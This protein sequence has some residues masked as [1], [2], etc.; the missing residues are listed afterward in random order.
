MI[1]IDKL[2]KCLT[3]DI[4]NYKEVA[5]KIGGLTDLMDADLSAILPEPTG[6]VFKE[7][8]DRFKDEITKASRERQ[9]KIKEVYNAIEESIKA[10]RDRLDSG[11]KKLGDTS[12]KSLLQDMQVLNRIS[13]EAE[14]G[15]RRIDELRISGELKT[16]SP[17]TRRIIIGK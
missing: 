4:K 10:R 11:L 16:A 2:A 5:P 14:L 9:T 8:V 6:D 12:I 1:D 15:A 13:T 3:E 17:R 7:I